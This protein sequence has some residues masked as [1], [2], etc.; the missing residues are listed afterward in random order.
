MSKE[1]GQLV[2]TVLDGKVGA[3]TLL[4]EKY[5]ITVYRYL[6]AMLSPTDSRIED[7]YQETFAAAFSGLSTLKNKDF[8]KP[9]L[10]GIASNKIKS[11]YR[12]RK[13][14]RELSENLA[15]EDTIGREEMARGGDTDRVR[16]AVKK[17]LLRLPEEMR[18]VITMKYFG[19]SSYEDIAEALDI[20][21]STVRGRMHR[22]Y[23]AL[24][25][26]FKEA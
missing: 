8:F 7:L 19:G 12:S 15:N 11:E 16:E 1:D 3:Y 23:Q 5:S 25:M 20:P 17:A 4:I 6:S 13:K 24:R 10:M 14:E 2:K 22:A 26:I 18:E 21:K 9:W